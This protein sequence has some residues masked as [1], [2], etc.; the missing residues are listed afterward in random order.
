MILLQYK[1]RSNYRGL[2]NSLCHCYEKLNKWD[3]SISYCRQLVKCNIVANGTNHPEYATAINSLATKYAQLKCFEQAIPLFESAI[4]IFQKTYGDQG[5]ITAAAIKHLALVRELAQR[6]H[7]ESIN[8]EHYYCMCNT[9]EKIVE[10]MDS[11]TACYKVSYCDKDCQLK[12]WPNHKL[13]CHVCLQCDTVLSRDSTILRCST[14]K[15]VKYCNVECQKAHWKEH[16]KSCVPIENI[17]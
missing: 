11:C 15:K 10:N 2:L 4:I 7:R 14:C 8:A 17:K 6:S 16:K 5:V 9:C 12:D 3:E 1:D 13:S